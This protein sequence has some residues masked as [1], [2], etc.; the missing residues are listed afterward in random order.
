MDDGVEIK[1]I[2]KEHADH[3]RPEE[4]PYISEADTH[5]RGREDERR[6]DEDGSGEEQTHETYLHRTQ[7]RSGQ[8]ANKDADDP[9]KDARKED[10]E[11]REHAQVL[12]HNIIITRL[13]G[14]YKF[15]R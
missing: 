10:G 14:L 12:L 6:N 5:M 7:P 3:S 2:E 8:L 15:L 11:D 1:E 4:Y 9:P 13:K